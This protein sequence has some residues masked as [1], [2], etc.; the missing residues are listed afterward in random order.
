M[1]GLALLLVAAPGCVAA[2]P[3]VDEWPPAPA[4]VLERESDPGKL[5]PSVTAEPLPDGR[6][7]CMFRFTPGPGPRQVALAGTFNGWNPA[8]TPFTGPDGNGRWS[9]TIELP[10]GP[11]FYKFVV[12]GTDWRPDPENADGEPDGHGGRNSALRLGQVANLTASPAV[13]GDG[14]INALALEHRQDT[15]LYFQRTSDHELL[16]RLRTLVDD[17]EKAAVSVQGGGLFDMTMVKTA[18]PFTWWEA[19]VRLPEVTAQP[20]VAAD[21]KEP[22]GYRYAFVLQ[23]GELR[24][25]SPQTYG[26]PLVADAIFRTP[27]WAKHAVWY[28]IMPDRFRNG[29]RA[30]DPDPVHPWTSEWFKLQPYEEARTGQTFYNWIVFDRLYGGDFDG[31]EEKLPYLKELGVNALYLNPVFIGDSHHKYNATNYLHIDP[32]FGPGDDDYEEIAAREDLRDP[33]TWEWTR[34]DRRFLAFLKAAKAQGFRVIIDGVFNH[35]GTKHPAFVDVQKRGRASRYADWFNVTSWEPF[36]YTGWGGFGALP[37]F[38]KTA[39][40]LASE[41]AKQHIFDVTRRWMAPDGDVSAGIDGWRLDVPNE[42]PMPFWVEWRDLVKAI[43]PDAYIVGEIWDR[44]DA[45]LDGRHFDAV[46]NYTFARAVVAWVFDRKTSISASEFDLRLRELRLAYPHE[47]TL[48]LQNLMNSHDTDRIASMAFNPD[49]AY[50]HANRV[51]DNGPNYNNAKPDAEAYARARLAALLQM[52]YIGAP[53]VYYGDEVG[54][55]GG[56]DPTCRKPMLWEDLQPYEAPEENYV[57]RPQLE[58]Y[59]RII[60]LRK[61]HPALRTGSVQTLLADDDRNVWAVL[62]KDA[63]EQLIIVATP[64]AQAQMVEVPVQPNAPRRW[65]G[66]FG[67][68]E[69]LEVVDG[70]LRLKVPALGGIVLHAATPK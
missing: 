30:N 22:G 25:S 29:N 69:T 8:A 39:T 47:A 31:L 28:Q 43:N 26:V 62:R 5:P 51:Q 23:D 12:N 21:G 54:M 53:M 7:R 58:H 38:R 10:S 44:A 67:T 61:A 33:A 68:E 65:Q 6:W 32:A 66:V 2:L 9:A 56:D 59:R 42:I 24:A 17:V 50:D 63:D 20:P 3:A 49:R 55:W 4:L 36:E 19:R 64:A 52:I 45:W 15:P 13:L 27:D 37:E 48:V 60:A 35:V 40:G 18:A 46:M 70:K 34:A 14:V 16:L 41:S 11:H 1:V 57:L